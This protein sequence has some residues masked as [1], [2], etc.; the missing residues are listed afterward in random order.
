MITRKVVELNK[1]QT[2]TAD[3]KE[4]MTIRGIIGK[5]VIRYFH[6]GKLV[7]SHNKTV[8]FYGIDSR[9]VGYIIPTSRTKTILEIIEGLEELG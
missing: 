5:T 2:I 4:G 9:L 1:E 6:V 3:Y 7:V 8:W